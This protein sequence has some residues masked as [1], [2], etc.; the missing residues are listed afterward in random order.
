MAIT[1]LLELSESGQRFEGYVL[2]KSVQDATTAGGSP[3]FNITVSKKHKSISSKLWENKFGGNSVVE[4]KKM[5]QSGSI[6]FIIGS[7]SEYRGE[8]Q[9]T[10]DEFR[11]CKEGEV[12]I[13]D[14][15]EAAP[16]P[17]EKLQKEYEQFLDDIQSPILH[18]ICQQ[19]YEDHKADFVTFPAAKSNHHAFVGGLLYHTVSMLR[20][21]KHIVSQYPQVNRNLLFASI[22]LHD[23]GKVVE[24]SGYVA[25]DYTKVGNFLGHITIV[26]ML[27]DRKA[28]KLKE[29]K[30]K[31]T[32]DD[33]DQIYEL[34]HIVSAHH[35]KLE[36]GS[37]VTSKI[38]EAEIIHHIDMI[39]SRINMISHAL[40]DE[41]LSEGEMKKIYPLGVYYKTTPNNL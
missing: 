19:L 15:L 37:P 28:Q 9:L 24:L 36:W 33:F 4:I 14:Y 17:I 27:I 8:S 6:H 13:T 16:E 21:A 1:C 23:L 7:I 2:I 34:M 30:D 29:D 11:L 41:N 10:I 35:G 31:W 3:Y 39:D 20:I 5:L 26:N 25:S 12:D 22:A 40:A 32:R 38:L 18:T